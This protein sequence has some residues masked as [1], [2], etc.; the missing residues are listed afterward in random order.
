MNND[1]TKTCGHGCY[2]LRE[3]TCTACADE[4]KARL[5]AETERL[6]KENEELRNSTLTMLADNRRKAILNTFL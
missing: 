6:K 5:K 3:Y 4:E 1:N 2:R